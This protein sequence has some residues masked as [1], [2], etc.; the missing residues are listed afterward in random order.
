MS[1]R[2]FS[3][4]ILYV[5]RIFS[6]HICCKDSHILDLPMGTSKPGIEDFKPIRCST[7]LVMVDLCCS[8]LFFMPHFIAL[9]D[10]V[11]HSQR[12]SKAYGGNLRWED[13]GIALLRDCFG[14]LLVSAL[15]AASLRWR[16]YQP[17]MG[18]PN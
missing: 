5:A 10:A 4:H 7:F 16:S 15:G 2:I 8:S 6:F 3:F 13:Q 12:Y 14:D 18:W 9:P 17:R 1:A 11:V